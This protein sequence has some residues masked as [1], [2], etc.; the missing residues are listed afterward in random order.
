MT[1]VMKEPTH[2]LENSK[3]CIDLIFIS[4]PNMVMDSSV[5]SSL[6][7]RCHHQIIYAEFNLKAF[8]PW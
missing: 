7:S 5:H 2:F 8:L 1:Q 6:R 3:S 4:Q